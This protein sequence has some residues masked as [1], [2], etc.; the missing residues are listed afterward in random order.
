MLFGVLF[1]QQSERQ[2]QF[3]Q[4]CQSAGVFPALLVVPLLL[5][6]VPLLLVPIRVVP[7]NSEE[8]SLALNVLLVFTAFM[9]KSAIFLF[10]HVV[11]RILSRL[12]S[13]IAT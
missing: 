10:V 7:P 12:G 1:T 9:Q 8:P 6:A 4:L 13:S 5:A 3:L 11:L 2:Q